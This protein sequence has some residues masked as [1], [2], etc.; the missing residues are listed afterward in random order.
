MTDV[1]A[2]LADAE[3][4]FDL[5]KVELGSLSMWQ[6]WLRF[7]PWLEDPQYIESIVAKV[8]AAGFIEPLLGRV[9]AQDVLVAGPNYRETISFQYINSRMRAVLLELADVPRSATVYAPEA[10]SAL[11]ARLSRRFHHFIGS[12]YLPTKQARLRHPRTR[13]EDVLRL[14]FRD[15]SIDVYVSCEVLEHVPSIPLAL[16]E[17]ARVLRPGGR[18]I[19]TV[20]FMYGSDSSTVRARLN[21]DAVEYLA[22]PEFHGNPVSDDGSLVFTLPGWDLLDDC[23]HA[24]FATAS[25]VACSSSRY[26]ITGAE[27]ACVFVL[28]AVK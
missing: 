21:G 14:S 16:T 19:A 1:I 18:L 8:T 22:E 3:R 2:S 10:L 27:I 5:V 15:A 4:P 23:R 24:G 17:A 28:T 25:I 12:E 9:S 11:A 7:N 20:P 6:R 13:H 26:A